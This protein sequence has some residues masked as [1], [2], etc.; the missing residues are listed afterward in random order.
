MAP[1]AA[2]EIRDLEIVDGS[3]ESLIVMS[4]AGQMDMG[5]DTRLFANRVN[6][7]QHLR[8]S[9]VHCACRVG[10]MVSNKNDRLLGSL[11]LRQGSLQKGQLLVV[12]G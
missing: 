2:N 4:V 10:R 3:S 7:S 9:A 8:A 5:P 1:V 12:D 11:G 6:V